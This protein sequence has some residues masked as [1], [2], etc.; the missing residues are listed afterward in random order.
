MEY[1]IQLQD[2]TKKYKNF[3]AVDHMNLHV[4]QGD[5]FAFLGVNGAGK[6]TTMNMIASLL[7]PTSGR[8]LIQGT[9]SNQHVKS[10]RKMIGF[11]FQDNVL[12]EE[13][14]V[15]AN[16][17]Y[18]GVLYGI[19]KKELQKRIQDLANIF[20][21]QGY[22]NKTYRQC[23]GGQKRLVSIARALLHKPK[24]VILD[25]PTTGL[26]SNIRQLVWKYL[27]KYQEEQKVTIFF[28]SHYIEEAMQADQIGIVAKGKIIMMDTPENIIENFGRK[29]LKIWMKDQMI[30]ME[31]KNA[32]QALQILHQKQ[33]FIHNF[34]CTT[35]SLEDVFL[36]CV[37]EAG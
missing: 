27:K 1:C 37:H 29:K 7:Q 25:E 33:N 4:D 12:D 6:S 14:S 23:S 3:L 16:L 10:V 22:L 2:V 20:D 24:L 5:V 9:L 13:C 8:I 28:T 26:D 18:R 34:A 36:H 15:Y 32:K 35:A 11:V 31:V 17:M 30:T 19:G 21:F